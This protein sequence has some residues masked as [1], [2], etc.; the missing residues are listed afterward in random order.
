MWRNSLLSGRSCGLNCDATVGESIA[1]ERDAS[2]R[3][4]SRAFQAGGAA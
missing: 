3:E 4:S 2:K 1:A